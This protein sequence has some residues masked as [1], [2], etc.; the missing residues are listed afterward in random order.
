MNVSR[1]LF[2]RAIIQSAVLEP[3]IPDVAGAGW[4]FSRVM[5][6]LQVTSVDQ[7]RAI[8]AEKLVPFGQTLRVVDD[9]Y[10]LRP[11]WSQCFNLASQPHSHR[12]PG[13]RS[14]SRAKPPRSLSRPTPNS[15][16]IVQLPSHLQPL[17]IGDACADSMLW[18]LPASHWSPSAITR[19]LKAICQSLSKA[20]TILN[21][22]DISHNTTDE[23]TVERVLELI[24]DARVAWPLECVAQNTKTER[25]G[26]GVFRY[27][28]DQE[29]P[30]RGLPHHA[31]DLIY[32]FDNVPLP[33][34]TRPATTPPSTPQE[35]PETFYSFSDD[36]DDGM[37]VIAEDGSD[38]DWVVTVDRFS[39]ARIRDTIQERWLAFAN[40]EAPWHED[41][42]FVFGPEGETG[43]RSSRIF[44]G[45][46]RKHTWKEVLEPMG[47]KLVNKIGV[48]LSRGPP[49]R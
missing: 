28:F 33:A 16:G 3:D 25:G 15:R 42:V 38:S 46:R 1:P 43:E 13:H 35:Y 20:S 31:T 24:N 10:L 44:E 2:H 40:G 7:L 47:L 26:K 21:A 36:D 18:K 14:V 4:Q 29:G 5:G 30:T 27:V 37:I 19:R 41:K 22:Y 45:R 8:D 12:S 39:Y 32:L 49:L 17:I 23:E 48:E 34:S 9:G 11:G 6:A